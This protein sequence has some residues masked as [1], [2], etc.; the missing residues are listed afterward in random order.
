MDPRSLRPPTICQRR[1]GEGPV[2]VDMGAAVAAQRWR[3][4]GSAPRSIQVLSCKY[5]LR[6]DIGP[7]W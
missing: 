4:S 7:I 3:P 5:S 6:R 1:E 2:V